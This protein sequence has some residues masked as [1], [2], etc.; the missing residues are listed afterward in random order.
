M[1]TGKLYRRLL[2]KLYN[3]FCLYQMT[4][5]PRAGL[6]GGEQSQRTRS[7]WFKI[8][9]RK[10][11]PRAVYLLSAGPCSEKNVGASI[12]AAD[13][14]FPGKKLA[15]FLV[16][17]IRA[18]VSCQFCSKTGDLFCS[19]LTRPLFPACKN[20]TILLWG[21]FLWGPCSSRTC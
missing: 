20:L 21:P 7:V 5:E 13:P 8:S 4:G 12:G 18:C 19:S 3:I 10:G 2:Y 17:T 14:I 6:L 16:I 15:T 1:L 11:R 9:G